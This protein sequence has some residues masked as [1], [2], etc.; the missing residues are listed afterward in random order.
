MVKWS[1]GGRGMDGKNKQSEKGVLG[2]KVRARGNRSSSEEGRDR[3]NRGNDR[4]IGKT[5]RRNEKM[6]IEG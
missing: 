1:G 5:R 4:G 2:R 6:R 3:N